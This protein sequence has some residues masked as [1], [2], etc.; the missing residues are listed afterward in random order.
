[1]SLRLLLAGIGMLVIAVVFFAVN[2]PAAG[3][4]FLVLMLVCGVV[5]L[6]QMG[7]ASREIRAWA[8]SIDS[9]DNK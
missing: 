5:A 6:V 3:A 9:D 2:I 4:V 7:R 1:M 8:R